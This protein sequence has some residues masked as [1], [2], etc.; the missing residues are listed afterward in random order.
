MDEIQRLIM[1]VEGEEKLKKLTQSQENQLKIMRQLV[2]AYDQGRMSQT[3]YEQRMEATAGVLSR[4]NQQIGEAQKGVKSMGGALMQA[5]YIVDDFVAGINNQGL[6]GALANIQNN[7]P[8]LLKSLGKGAGLAGVVGIAGVG[9]AQLVRHW[10]ELAGLWKDGGVEQA[11]EA[12]KKYGEAAQKAADA[13]NQQ[14]EAVRKQKTAEQSAAGAA[15]AGVTSGADFDKVLDQIKGF[16]SGAIDKEKRRL[17]GAA[18]A[19]DRIAEDA[20]RASPLGVGPYGVKDPRIAEAQAKAKEFRDQIATLVDSQKNAMDKGKSLI[21][22]ARNGDMDAYDEL[23]ASTTGDVHDQLVAADPRK[24]GMRANARDRA[25]RQISDAISDF[26]NPI[27][28]ALKDR[29]A[30]EKAKL[31]DDAATDAL[32]DVGRGNEAAWRRGMQDDAA[33][34]KTDAEKARKA[35]Y[36]R[37]LKRDRADVAEEDRSFLEAQQQQQD[38]GYGGGMGGGGDGAGWEEPPRQTY[39]PMSHAERI[40]ANRRRKAR[41]AGQGGGG[42]GFR[43]VAPT[44]GGD[45]GGGD[46]RQAVQAAVGD[47]QQVVAAGNWQGAF[48]QLAGVI[49]GV[50]RQQMMLRQQMGGQF[51][52]QMNGGGFSAQ[53]TFNGPGI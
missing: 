50:A 6:A 29:R 26:M 33:K 46:P 30:S 53:P 28:T 18:A 32:N 48:Q 38:G 10:D 25:K 23:L 20:T 42:G 49:Q 7:I 15:V 27:A 5:G 36:N 45:G 24:A 12:M 17:Q 47:L 37:L 31:A 11:T 39:R 4:T 40:E 51:R 22:R 9:V 3:A 2:E 14:V 52:G 35:D 8:G 1:Q 41:R 34:A 13:F 19:Q 21:L 43:S 44:E 16:D